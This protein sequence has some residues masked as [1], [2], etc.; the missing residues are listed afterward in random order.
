VVWDGSIMGEYIAVKS[1]IGFL[2]SDSD[3]RWNSGA[4]VAAG[5]ENE[6]WTLEVAIPWKAFGDTI[7]GVTGRS[8]GFNLCRH[9]IPSEETSNWSKLDGVGGNHNPRRFGLL[10]L[11]ENSPFVSLV[12]PPEFSVG[13]DAL[14]IT[15]QNPIEQEARMNGK[16]IAAGSASSGGEANAS[17][18][19]G[20]EQVLKLPY[21]ISGT[22][23]T[24]MISAEIRNGDN[25]FF[26]GQYEGVVP[27]PLII[28]LPRKDVLSSKK[29]ERVAIEVA[30]SSDE[31]GRCLLQLELLDAKGKVIRNQQLKPI[32]SRFMEVT[33][34][35]SGLKVGRYTLRGAIIDSN[36]KSIASQD[37]PLNVITDPLDF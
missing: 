12:Q 6:A 14:K 28:D 1:Q 18:P 29:T 22:N 34:D 25:V 26:S 11:G 32:P 13:L 8:L 20:N 16:L 7:G 30:V 33:F 17:V 5:R 23:Q 24:A 21:K 2:R 4:K 3:V 10:V 15:V 36:G 27:P 35:V 37:A 31:L 19:A 9:R